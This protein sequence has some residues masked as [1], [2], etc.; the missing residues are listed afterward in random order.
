MSSIFSLPS[1]ARQARYQRGCTAEDHACAWL[2]HK[3][4]LIK[5]RRLRTPYGEIDIIAQH[6]NTV[7]FIEVKAR[8]SS[9]DAFYA[10]SQ[11][12]RQRITHAALHYLSTQPHDGDVR[13]D[14]IAVNH[15]DEV[16]HLPH[17]WDAE[18]C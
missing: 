13:F 2:E 10:I 7:V 11:Q 1:R 12:Q 14:V 17:A 8:H 18:Y 16:M 5:A 3:D 9:D 6:G 15:A 4:Y